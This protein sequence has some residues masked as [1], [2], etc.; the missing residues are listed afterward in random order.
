MKQLVFVY[1]TLRRGESNQ[2][3]L[4]RADCLGTH[5][6]EPVYT[7]FNL[8]FF[9]AIVPGGATAIVGEVFAVDTA[10]L[11]MLDSFEECP[12]EYIR[13]QVTTPFGEAWIYVYRHIPKDA[14]VI[15]SGDWCDR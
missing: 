2:H 12:E 11:A 4:R 1:G 14:A 5:K 13:D 15:P 3:M 7:M 6:T 9:P 10:T 8:G